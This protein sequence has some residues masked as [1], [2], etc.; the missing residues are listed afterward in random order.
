M[1]A[2]ATS[3]SNGRLEA[4]LRAGRFVMTAETSPLDER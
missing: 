4:A 2:T 3:R 1:N